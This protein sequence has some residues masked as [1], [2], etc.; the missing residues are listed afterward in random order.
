MYK[1]KQ[2][3]KQIPKTTIFAK[4]A[5]EDESLREDKVIQVITLY[6]RNSLG[7]AGQCNEVLKK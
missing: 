2:K 7:F 5:G 4:H 6:V 1:L 3:A